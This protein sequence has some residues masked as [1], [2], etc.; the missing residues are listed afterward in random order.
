MESDKTLIKI[1]CANKF[2]NCTASR[3]VSGLLTRRQDI[4]GSCNNI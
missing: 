4:S 2:N 3:D 1:K